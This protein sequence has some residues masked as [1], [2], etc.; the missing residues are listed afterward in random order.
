MRIE[1][2]ARRTL[3]GKRWFF[4]IKASNGEPIAQSEA[5]HNRGDAYDTAQLLRSKLFDAQLIYR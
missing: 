2:F 5:Y 4:T 1:I 3:R